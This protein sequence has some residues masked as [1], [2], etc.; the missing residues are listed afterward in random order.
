MDIFKKTALCVVVSFSLIACGGGG[1]TPT[2]NSDTAMPTNF[3]YPSS[4]V[5]PL[6]DNIE[7]QRQN[8]GDAIAFSDGSLWYIT[9]THSSGLDVG[10]NHEF[11]VYVSTDSFS[12]PTN[13]VRGSHYMFIKG[14]TR[15]FYLRPISSLG[16]R[17]KD[18]IDFQRQSTG[19]LIALTD[20]SL[21][22][23]MGTHNSSYDV[24]GKHNV[25]IYKNAK[26]IPVLNTSGQR[27]DDYMYVSGASR[28]FYIESLSNVKIN[29]RDKVVFN[30]HTTGDTVALSDGSLWII[31]GR[32][33]LGY[34]VLDSHAVII[35]TSVDSISNPKSGV[36]SGY[37]MYI[38]GSSVG[39]FVE[40]I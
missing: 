35:Y 16:I 12:A 9:G 11:T 13:G 10:D 30:R 38:S 6:T 40:P 4:W 1:D 25:T 28:G 5:F 39:F 21:W 19:D 7:F 20:G 32:H 8:T 3:E 22:S 27:T 14:S 34:D 15:S 18:A 36:R 29:I 23:I 24:L 33:N 26:D 2:N 37:Y 17:V 31:K